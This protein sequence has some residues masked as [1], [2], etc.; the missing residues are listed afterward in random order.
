MEQVLVVTDTTSG[1]AFAIITEK[2]GSLRFFGMTDPGKEWALWLEAATN[3]R[4]R[5]DEIVKRLSVG[6][7]ADGPKPMTRKVRSELAENLPKVSESDHQELTTGRVESKSLEQGIKQSR[8]GLSHKQWNALINFKALSFVNDQN[9][10]SITYDLKAARA[11]FDPNLAGGNGGYRCPVGTRYGGQITDRYGRG[12]GWGVARRLVNAIGDAARNV[13]RRLD[14]RRKRRVER[15]N[16]RVG[17][18]L[19]I[20]KPS[21][22]GRRQRG[23]AT[24]LEDFADRRDQ[25]QGRGIATRLEDFADRRDERQGVARRVRRGPTSIDTPPPVRRNNRRQRE[26][27]VPEQVKPESVRSRRRS[28]SIDRVNDQPE[29][30]KKPASVPVVE[31]QRPAKKVVAKKRAAKKA[32]AKKAPAKKV[33]AKKVAAKKAVAKKAP[34]KKA[35]ASRNLGPERAPLLQ[36]LNNE[37]RGWVLNKFDFRHGNDENIIARRIADPEANLE[38]DIANNERQIERQRAILE[39]RELSDRERALADLKIARIEFNNRSLRNALKEREAA[40][41]AKKVAAKKRAARKAVASGNVDI[42]NQRRLEKIEKNLNDWVDRV[43]DDGERQKVINAFF[44]EEQ[45]LLRLA[46]AVPSENAN[47]L[48]REAAIYRAAIR[49]LRKR[50]FPNAPQSNPPT[51]KVSAKK[52]AAARGTPRLIDLDLETRARVRKELEAIYLDGGARERENNR[53][54][55]AES[56]NQLEQRIRF[57]ENEVIPSSRKKANDTNLPLDQRVFYA[58]SVAIHRERIAAYRDGIQRKR[59]LAAAKPEV[60]I[61]NI[62]IPGMDA[63]KVKK[64]QDEVAKRYSELRKK[65]AKILGQY[66]VKRYGSGNPPPWKTDQNLSLKTLREMAERGWTA[67]DKEKAQEWIK[68]IYEHDEII[69]RNGLKFRTKLDGNV[70]FRGDSRIGRFNGRIEAFNTATGRW[71]QVGKF[72]RTI[73]WNNPEHPD[74]YVYNNFMM[75]GSDAGFGSSF[76]NAAKNEGFTSVFNPHAFTWLK[77]AGF[78]QAG[79]SA[80]ADGEFV[81]GRAGF[82]QDMTVDHWRN[83]ANLGK[84]GEV[85]AAAL[86]QEVKR[87]KDG[88]GSDII[89]TDLDADLITYL[90]SVARA[91]NFSTDAPQH[92]EYILALVGDKNFTERQKKTFDK[93]LKQWFVRTSA[94]THGKFVFTDDNVPDDPRK[95]V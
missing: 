44:D 2:N 18:H 68:R 41:P 66:M 42:Q 9:L 34:A 30:G 24:R 49:R 61:E 6:L 54:V 64:L 90:T 51:K 95:L 1:D 65:R 55:E 4:G 78:K 53:V 33:A 17:R 15:R 20:D 73:H 50:D 28:A 57:L 36:Q 94:F 21:V 38:V 40:R 70:D 37:D 10:S 11:V 67:Q 29:A 82:R 12:C 56:I 31:R 80:A 26:L 81:W 60:A 87:F 63:Q 48:E 35:V 7:S 84:R 58:E 85:L 45:G 86:E 75:I 23:I 88:K 76:A 59:E 5:L 19:G 74:G 39:N 46:A 43:A 93:K 8:R 3:G 77:A 52:R 47:A 83:G 69:G 32:P 89:R 14:D 91:K 72:T 71:E 62:A 92:P 27:D 25:R 22:S 13:E 79:V 16:R